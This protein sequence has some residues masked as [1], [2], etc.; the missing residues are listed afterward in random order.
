MA[1]FTN[2]ATLSYSGGVVNSNIAVGE[3]VEVLSADKTALRSTYGRGDTV[4]Y[5]VSAVNSGTTPITGVTVVDN[6]GAYAFG[7]GTL[8]PLDYVDGSVRLYIN[9]VL[10]AAPAVATDTDGVTFSGITLPAGGNL[11]LIYE[12]T[13]NE[14][15]A[16]GDPGSI[17]NTAT[18]NGAGVVTPI[19]ATETVNA[20][21][22]PSLTIAKSIEPVPV[23]DNGT[24]T[25]RFVIQNYGNAAAGADDA[26]ILS[27]TFDP[28]LE[29]IA[30]TYNGAPFTD[31]TY[32]E[33]A[34]EFTTTAGAITVPAAT[35]VQN[36]DGV[37]VA[38]PGVTTL[39][40]SGTI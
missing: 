25:Y 6:L 19:V 9:G 12:T 33:A 32:N 23:A 11:V 14:F 22:E 29:N 30:V 39:T 8:V 7:D 20:A 24:L 27:D 18:V 34:G 36:E 2:Q 26:V 4:T 35:Y 21:S 3:I 38:T 10:A 28:I 37:W 5:I 13:V 1:Q 15:A 17:V 40:V 16:P 31:Y